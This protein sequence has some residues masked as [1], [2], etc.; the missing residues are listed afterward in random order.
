M[1]LRDPKSRDSVDGRAD[2]YVDVAGNLVPVDDSG[3]FEHPAISEEWAEAYAE[4]EGMDVSAV[5]VEDAAQEAP[6]DAESDT[7]ETVK[8]DGD[9]CGRERPCPYHDD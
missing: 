4:R 9:V 5:L 2:G 3:E 1:R 6:D 7:C 8:Q